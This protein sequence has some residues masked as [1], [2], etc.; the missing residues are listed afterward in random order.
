MAV[1]TYTI[2]FNLPEFPGEYAVQGW[3]SHLNTSEP[4]G[5]IQTA[6]TLDAARL[7]VPSGMTYLHRHPTDD[8]TIVE[9]WV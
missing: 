7:L 3:T 6:A 2:Y 8:P 1:R 4:D 9:V 5:D